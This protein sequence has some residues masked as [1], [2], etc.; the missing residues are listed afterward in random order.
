MVDTKLFAPSLNC[1]RKPQWGPM[2][3]AVIERWPHI[4]CTYSY[5]M[6][7]VFELHYLC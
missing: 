5:C 1:V 2:R 6:A 4:E 7:C 3:V